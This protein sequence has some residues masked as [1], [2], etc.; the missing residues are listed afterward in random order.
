MPLD[1]PV[2]GGAL[3]QNA[4]SSRTNPIL[5][6]RFG[7][8]EFPALRESKENRRR[9]KSKEIPKT[10]T[11]DHVFLCEPLFGQLSLGLREHGGNL[12]WSSSL[13]IQLVESMLSGL[14]RYPL[15]GERVEQSK[16]F[17]A[18]INHEKSSVLGE[19]M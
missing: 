18:Q 6:R 12:V 13:E 4:A 9:K 10:R 14:C 5:A 15:N 19:G 3:P 7:P 17:W 11:G 8:G 1:F 16:F 2:S